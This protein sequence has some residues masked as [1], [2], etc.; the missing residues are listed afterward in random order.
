MP[1]D[2]GTYEGPPAAN[3]RNSVSFPVFVVDFSPFRAAHGAGGR[4]FETLLSDAEER[5]KIVSRVRI[6]S[7]NEGGGRLLAERMAPGEG[8]IP[9]DK[10][11][12]ESWN[13]LARAL[14]GFLSDRNLVEFPFHVMGHGGIA[15][16][17]SLR[18][19]LPDESKESWSRVVASLIRID[20]PEPLPSKAGDADVRQLFFNMI[21]GFALVE[22]MPGS[23]GGP[24]DFRFLSVNP[25]FERMMGLLGT[26][27]LGRTV[28]DLLPDLDEDWI[29]KY[30][31][32]VRTGR[33]LFAQGFSFDS[34][35]YFDI[36]AYRP[37]LNRMAALVQDVS[38]REKAFRIVHKQRESL[39]LALDAAGAGTWSLDL[40]SGRFDADERCAA[41]LGRK[42]E[43]LGTDEAGWE[44]LFHPD[45]LDGYRQMKH[46]CLIGD[47]NRYECELRGRHKDG[48]W[49]WFLE[50]GNVAERSFDGRPL[51]MIGTLLNQDRRK[52]A[53]LEASEKGA[54]LISL[55]DSLDDLAFFTDREGTLMGC[56]KALERFLGLSAQG[57]VGKS[58]EEGFPT[59]VAQS[60]RERNRIVLETEKPVRVEEWHQSAENGQWVLLEVYKNPLRDESGA[61]V[62]IASVA[63]NTTERYEAT[64]AANIRLALLERSRDMS[65]SALARFALEELERLTGSSGG[66]FYNLGGKDAAELLAWHAFPGSGRPAEPPHVLTL[67]ADPCAASLCVRER[68]VLLYNDLD[69]GPERPLPDGC[70]SYVRCVLVP[71]LRKDLVV[72]ILGVVDKK[73]PYSRRDVE[74]LSAL[75]DQIWDVIDTQ[76]SAEKRA[77]S[78]RLR[79]TALS[80]TKAGFWTSLVSTGEGRLDGR[81]AAILGYS[82]EEVSANFVEAWK[83]LCHPDDFAYSMQVMESYLRGEAP[84]FEAEM[85]LRH[86]DGRWIWVLDRGEVVE[87]DPSGAPV[88]MA[89]I[90]IDVTRLKE[91]ELRLRETLA[92]KEA[93]LHELHH[94]TNNAMQLINAMLE[95]KKADLEYEPA[96][97]G[98]NSVQNKIIAISLVQ[99]KLFQA[100]SLSNLDFGDFLKDLV[101]ILQRQMIFGGDRSFSFEVEAASAKVSVDAAIPCGI[102]V[103]ELIENSA[104]H[105]FPDGGKG[106][107]RVGLAVEPDTTIRLDVSDNGMGLPA[108]FDP[109]ASKKIGLQTVIGIAEEQLHGEVRFGKEKTGF[110]VS[111]RFKD[112][113][114]PKRL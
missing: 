29:R 14:D 32:V 59:E 25:V 108:G 30:E 31:D 114:Y 61:T 98:I 70:P 51:R 69:S 113:H 62:G 7:V 57:I 38:G 6:V 3:T 16:S 78:E 41:L 19:Q 35:R 76:I 72:S 110:S 17:Y 104:R 111:I 52:R 49:L 22:M 36:W 105:A 24:G 23:G 83:T 55:L 2:E 26:A 99:E 64:L 48:R 100:S 97:Q 93:L 95:F 47:T 21:L 33:P 27:I 88:R 81:C 53:E 68:R 80:V 1:D 107:V 84:I 11:D 109:R 34:N 96:V 75:A 28:R 56:N 5:G 12:E 73:D 87:R 18:L 86:K 9:W 65:G 66:F 77:E 58:I 106:I 13:L 102:I 89:G 103:T 15:R 90:L 85:R 79:E 101:D 8:Y 82:V 94:R 46:R 50:R 112:I 60:M 20:R 91:S 45:D 4:D 71:I 92:D 43:D 42:P 74:R 39:D 67:G 37:S 10:L 54:R 63:R 44:N 40:S